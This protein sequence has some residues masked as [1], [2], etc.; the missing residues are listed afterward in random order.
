MLFNLLAITLILYFYVFVSFCNL[1]IYAEVQVSKS[2]KT[3]SLY[4]V[5][6]I[7]IAYLT[8]DIIIIAL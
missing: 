3:I 6:Y 1:V 2:I 7:Y 4:H 5:P 8:S